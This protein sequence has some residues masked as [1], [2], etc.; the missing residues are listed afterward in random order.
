MES[1]HVAG[2]GSLQLTLSRT[3]YRLFFGTNL[4]CARELAGRYGREVMANPVGLSVGLVSA[5]GFVLMGRRNVA[6]AYYPE[7][8]HPFAGSLEPREPVERVDVFEDAMRELAEEVGLRGEDVDEMHCAGIVEDQTL[9]QPEMIFLARCRRGRAEIE[10]QLDRAE[11]REVWAVE[12]RV[13]AVERA[14]VEERAEMTPVGVGTL[15]L[16]GRDSAGEE[17]FGREAA[18]VAARV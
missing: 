6:V 14:L 17:W 2:D 11:H 10:G 8:I 18:R 16:W 4:R 7:R 12:A 9:L 5:D 15:L 1:S 3:S 13:E